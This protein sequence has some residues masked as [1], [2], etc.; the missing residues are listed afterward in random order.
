V[1]SEHHRGRA[2]VL[3]VA[4]A[5]ALTLA[6]AA[7]G[8]GGGG[9]GASPPSE[10]V[11]VD[12]R[13]R[14]DRVP[15]DP[16]TG[17]LDYGAMRAAPARGV[18]VEA[19]DPQ[20]R[21]L[22]ETATDDGGRYALQVA[23]GRT[24]RIRVQAR[25][26]RLGTPSWDFEVVDNTSEDLRYALESEPIDLGPS[27]QTVN[28]RADS[29]WDG[30][31]YAGP[32]AAAPFAILDT[33][34]TAVE[35][36]LD[37]DPTTDFPPLALHWSPLN[38][39]SDAFAPDDGQI[40]TTAYIIDPLGT[41]IFILGDENV[42][43]DEYDAHVL[44]HEWGHYLEE[45]LAR[46]DS[47]GG[48]HTLSARLDPRVAFSEG[49]SNA[50]AGIALDDPL[51]NDSLG[52]GQSFGFTFDLE[53]NGGFTRGWYVESS[54]HSILYDLYDDRDDDFDTVALGFGPLYRTFVGAHADSEALTSI[55]S[56]ATPL[57]SDNENAASAVDAL[58]EA[59]NIVGV[60]MNIWAGGETNDAGVADVLPVYTDAVV[61][62]GP[63]TV[64]SNPQFGLFNRLGVRQFIRFEA[65]SP[66]PHRMSA[67][68]GNGTDPDL[69]LF[70]G[71]FLAISE[72]AVADREVFTYVL[73]TGAYV[74][75]VYEFEN[76]YAPGQGRTCFDVT[77]E[78]I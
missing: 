42:D 28:L 36:V 32:R 75:E 5:L 63:V 56:F 78:A 14:F 21:V 25:M 66:G 72:T 67:V 39:E 1:T 23:A 26:R 27:G 33:V 77:V 12:G 73:E 50:F 65:T 18:I 58:L 2:G 34:R 8:G 15:T 48:P 68:G 71:G 76:L 69:V 46:T 74:L 7:C 53:D 60:G 62:G 57:K 37:A 17:G 13:I 31:S 10:V 59:Q 19:V 52:P 47:P 70:R 55:F 40:V 4:A 29:G 30:A 6:A 22:A 45:Q 54:I 24:L 20:G 3:R 49:W 9:G 38:R 11:T 51:Y 41:G 35:R 43:T 44:A 16:A 64:C 61:G